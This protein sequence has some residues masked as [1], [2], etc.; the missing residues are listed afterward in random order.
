M[1][2]YRASLPRI[3]VPTISSTAR[4]YLESTR[5]HLTPAEYAQTE[6]ADHVWTITRDSSAHGD[7]WPQ[8]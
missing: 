5:P 8:T 4:K 1:L 6:A 3:P 2:R 7:R